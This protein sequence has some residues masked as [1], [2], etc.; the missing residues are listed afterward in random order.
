[1]KSLPAFLRLVALAVA[2]AASAGIAGAQGFPRL[3]DVS[4]VSAGDVL[5]V[6]AGPTTRAEIVATLP[7]DRRDVEVMGLSEDGRWAEIALGEIGGWAALRYLAPQPARAEDRVPA[8]LR[9]VGT[10]PFWGMHFPGD[11]SATFERPPDPDLPMRVVSQ[12]RPEGTVGRLA[13]TLDGDP[14]RAVVFLTREACTDG[15]SERPYGLSVSLQLDLADG[16]VAYAGCC[17]LTG[18]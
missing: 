12:V 5:N 8:P 3:Y 18:P 6:R 17:A 4:G 14:A 13:V 9:C 1:M 16:P 10:E 15:M 11:G 2:L 7:S